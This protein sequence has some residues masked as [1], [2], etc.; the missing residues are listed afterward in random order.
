MNPQSPACVR[1]GAKPVT[2]ASTMIS[3]QKEGGR[4]RISLGSAYLFLTRC[5][6]V[7]DAHAKL[8]S[9]VSASVAARLRNWS[10]LLS[11]ASPPFR[12]RGH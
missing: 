5:T 10:G 3:R 12:Q 7:G 6:S 4:L 11:G 9:G 2:R 1:R 8:V